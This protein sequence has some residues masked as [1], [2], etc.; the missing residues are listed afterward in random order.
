MSLRELEIARTHDTA[1]SGWTSTS[2]SRHPL[3]VRC[4]RASISGLL[5]KSPRGARRAHL[6]DV[7]RERVKKLVRDDNREHVLICPAN[8]LDVQRK[9]S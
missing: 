7:D 4:E 8:V 5:Q 1:E 6:E 2:T 3:L 9:Y